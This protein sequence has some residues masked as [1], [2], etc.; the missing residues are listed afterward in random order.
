MK[1]EK[2]SSDGVVVN[3]SHGNRKK[4]LD[5]QGFS[6]GGKSEL[7]KQLDREGSCAVYKNSVPYVKK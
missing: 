2:F 7:H 1:D 6:S 3:I 4:K 5:V